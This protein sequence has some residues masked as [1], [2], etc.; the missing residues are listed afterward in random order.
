MR[1]AF[2]CIVIAAG[3]LTNGQARQL[4]STSTP[5]QF[6]FEFRE[7]LL[8]IKVQVPESKERLNFLLDSGAEASVVNLETARELSLKPGQPV[9]VRGVGVAMSGYWTMTREARVGQ[10]RVPNRLLALDL[11]QLSRSC[12]CRVDG[13]LGSDFFAG[14]VVQISF[15]DSTIRLLDSAT[16]TPGAC[17][18]MELRR[19]AVRMKAE[20][21]ANRA[22]WFRVD[23]GC[24]TPLQW[25]NRQ[26]SPEESSTKLAVGLA[27]M[28]IPQT[29]ATVKLAAETLTCVETGLHTTPIFE[30][31]AGLIGNGLLSRFQTVTLD[32]P[33]NRVILGARW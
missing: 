18:P 12:S 22:Q 10:V 33:H 20:V 17:V 5:V 13:L 4:P 30:G 25:V 19:G 26:I 1:L 6:P 24:A 8:W 15:R 21:N 9:P 31:E 27:E 28:S 2:L 16:P 29:R 23:T 14:R 11:D 7:G 3:C 32:F